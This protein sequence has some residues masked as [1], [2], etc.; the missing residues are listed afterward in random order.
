MEARQFGPWLKAA[1]F[2][3]ARKNVISM[4]G[5]F[6][7]KKLDMLEGPSRRDINPPCTMEPIVPIMAAN[8]FPK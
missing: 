6:S 3:G 7:R 8:L 1:P 4:P 2:V 5:F